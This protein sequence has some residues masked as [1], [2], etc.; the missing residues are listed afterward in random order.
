[1][2]ISPDFWQIEHHD[3]VT[4]TMDVASMRAKAGARAGLVVAADEQTAGRGQFGRVWLA[5]PGRCLLCTVLLRPPIQVAMS[6]TLSRDIAEQVAIAVSDL[7]GLPLQVKDPNDV[8]CHG[9]K[10]S[11]ILS[12]TSIRGD[13]LEYLLIGIGLNVN[14]SQDELPV[15]T[16]TSLLVETDQ[17]WEK[18]RLLGAILQRLDKIPGLIPAP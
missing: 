13:R 1:M 8:L 18:E 17:E 4:S 12:T 3:A 16:A 15:P 10:L 2:S 14:L 6:P 5:P 9:R 7:T 11:G